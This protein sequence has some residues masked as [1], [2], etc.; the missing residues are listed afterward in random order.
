[1]VVILSIPIFRRMAVPMLPIVCLLMAVLKSFGM[2]MTSLVVMAFGFL[3]RLMCIIAKAVHSLSLKGKIIS[4]VC[5]NL[6]SPVS[7]LPLRLI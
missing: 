1:M 6:V 7:V 4:S 5:V 3:I 2:A